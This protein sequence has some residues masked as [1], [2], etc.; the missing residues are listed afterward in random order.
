MTHPHIIK[1]VGMP[2]SGTGFAATVLSM[3]PECIAY[4]ELASSDPN[5]KNTIANNECDYVV[6]ATTYG[7]M[8]SA[9]IPCAVTIYLNRDPV[10]SL[11]SC[12]RAFG[13]RVEPSEMERLHHEGIK[14]AMENEAEFFND[15][16]VFTLEG[17]ERLWICA[18]G[19]HVDFPADKMIQLQKMNIQHH[20]SRVLFGEGEFKI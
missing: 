20:N 2:R 3:Y 11:E 6:D 9:Q 13:R 19:K 15:G 5:W 7:H 17:M 8:K 16:E 14:W 18:Y 1:I 4:H 12:T 10:G